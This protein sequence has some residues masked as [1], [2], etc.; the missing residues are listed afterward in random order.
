LD[1]TTISLLIR[2]FNITAA[3]VIG[4]FAA[5]GVITVFLKK[6]NLNIFRKKM[7]LQ[8]FCVAAMIAVGLETAAFNYKHFLKYFADGE[9]HT[10]EVSPENPAVILTSDRAVSAEIL[11]KTNND[12][13]ISSG[14]TFNNLDRRVTSVYVKPA[15]N[16]TDIL[17][18]YIRWTDAGTSRGL[19]KKLYK[20]LPHE[21]HTALQLYG[22]V[23][24]LTILFPER[25][26]FDEISHIAINKQ[27]PFYFNGLRLF[28]VSCLFFAVILFLNRKLRAQTAY[29]LFEYKFDPAN[30]K[31]N[32]AYILSAFLL[33]I[34]SWICVYTSTEE[35]LQSTPM[36]RQYN[37]Y[38]VDAFIAGR[39]YLNWGNAEKLLNAER[40]YDYQWLISNGYESGVDWAWDMPHYKGK[41]YTYYGPVPAILLYLPY[42]L[43]TGDYLSHNTAVFLFTSITIILLAL[44]WRFLVK[45]YMPDS[46]FAFYLLSFLA[47]FFASHI[48]AA[49]RYP[50]VWTIVQISGVAFSIAGLL[51]LLKSI[52]REE[53]TNYL[54]LFFACFCFAL[55]VGCRPNMLIASLIVPVVL[56]K[57]RSWRLALFAL[58]PY[59]I[60]AIPM[61]IY[62][63]VRFDSIFEFGHK[64]CIGLGGGGGIAH[65]LNPLAQIHRAVITL[66]LYLFR[67]YIYSL[68]F[69]FVE[70]IPITSFVA[71]GLDFFKLHNGAA[72]I[73]NFPIVFCLLYLFKVISSKNRPNGFCLLS[74]FSIVAALM[75][76]Q[77]SHMGIFHG[78]Y[79]LDCM[80]F[81]LLS[82]LFCA[83][84]WSNSQN[85][86]FQ[87]RT[88]LKIVY[89]LLAATVFVGLL[90]FATWGDIGIHT[91]GDYGNPALYRYLESSFGIIGRI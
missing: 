38:L 20:G 56:W 14:V 89:A 26:F 50:A 27:I 49:L 62:N 1:N 90:L 3:T 61:C 13:V 88:H 86:I 43:I 23:S 41:F 55:A 4:F 53:K 74:V 65:L 77:F 2:C 6:S 52:E 5:Y 25:A 32:L 21:N 9:F 83:Y 30:K 12:T 71:T 34:F 16:N 68:H 31:Q 8:A 24:E 17:D 76:V 60:V 7:F 10:T 63:Y 66:S 36:N 42:K 81:I 67:P 91:Y 69:P 29:F 22:N 46:R 54:M 75:I 19:E 47:L 85:D 82:S 40:P 57:R 37:E 11:I 35:Y 70:L 87:D 48:F 72:G 18:M 84:Y 51:L 78:R 33:I 79:L 15:F 39:T 45:K 73:I 64:Y 59:M 28:V 44:L 80:L 58:L